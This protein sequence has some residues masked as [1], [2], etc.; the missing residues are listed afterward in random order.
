MPHKRSTLVL[1]VGAIKEGLGQVPLLA[2]GLG[3]SNSVVD[4]RR[5]DAAQGP[6]PLQGK[7]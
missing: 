6:L 7:T 1:F 4:C 5:Y 2:D 3:G